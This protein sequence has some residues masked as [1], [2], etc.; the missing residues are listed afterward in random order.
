LVIGPE[1]DPDA[2]PDASAGLLAP[3]DPV[4]SPPDAALP[5]PPALLDDGAP[6]VMAAVVSAVEPEDPAVGAF[7][8][9]P[10][11]ATIV[12]RPTAPTAAS[13]LRFIST[14]L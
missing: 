13:L 6:E 2:E 14:P 9:H 10:A 3:V 11:S 12:A 1:S 8:A 5:V 7:D 4:L